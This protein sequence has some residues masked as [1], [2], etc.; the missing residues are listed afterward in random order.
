[1]R[2]SGKFFGELKFPKPREM[3]NAPN[4]SEQTNGPLTPRFLLYV[5]VLLNVLFDIFPD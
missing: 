3:E 2:S 4:P 5:L 1:M